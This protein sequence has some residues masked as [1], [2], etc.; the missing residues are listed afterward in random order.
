MRRREK[1]KMPDEPTQLSEET[2]PEVELAYT[3]PFDPVIGSEFPVYVAKSG[4]N[5]WWADSVKLQKLIVAFQN[6]C[7]ITQANIYAG[8]SYQ[9]Y[10]DFNR[11][12]PEF[13]LVKERCGEV[14]GLQAKMTFGKG[15]KKDHWLAHAYLKAREPD[16]FAERPPESPIP[17][18]GGSVATITE[19]AFM[20]E[21]GKVI[22]HEKTAKLITD[23]GSPT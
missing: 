11:I 6:G 14:F 7:N 1:Q 5:P 19:S 23:H 3:L 13:Y 2:L 22:A 8:I 16:N 17:P 10:E 12:H 9:Q 4:R 15:L 21:S 20:D 18:Q